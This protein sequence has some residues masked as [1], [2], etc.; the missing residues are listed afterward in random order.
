MSQEIPLPPLPEPDVEWPDR[1]HGTE[2]AHSDEQM[3]N[4]ARA[5]V[6]KALQ[7]PLPQPSE[8]SEQA[9]FNVVWDD[10]AP[11]GIGAR[12]NE[13]RQLFLDGWTHAIAWR[14]SVGLDQ[15]DWQPPQ[16]AE[17]DALEMELRHARENLVKSGATLIDRDESLYLSAVDAI[18]AL[19]RQ[20]ADE[21]SFRQRVQAGL[22]RWLPMADFSEQAADD[23]YLLVCM[24]TDEN[25]HL[26]QQLRERA[27]K[28]E[29]ELLE[30]RKVFSEAG[31]TFDVSYVRRLVGTERELAAARKQIERRDDDDEKNGIVLADWIERNRT[32]NQELVI[33]RQEIEALK[34][35]AKRYRWLIEDTRNMEDVGCKFSAGRMSPEDVDAAIDAARGNK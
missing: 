17:L 35:D 19:R 6:Y 5:A 16:D 11:D 28:A 32:L 23:A 14:K 20:V 8:M 31:A 29:R 22:S 27:E 2:Y 24:D 12:T 25:P 9:A 21:E 13:P 15:K 7:P 10:Y 30:M 18:V 1:Y 3:R 26:G 4:Y 34:P 33:A